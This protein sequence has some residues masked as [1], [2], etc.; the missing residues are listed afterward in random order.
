MAAAT[1]SPSLLL[2]PSCC[3]C[4]ESTL[5]LPCGSFLLGT[6]IQ[7]CLE[8]AVVAAVGKGALAWA[9]GSRS[10]K[11]TEMVRKRYLWLPAGPAF[12]RIQAAA[13]A[14]PPPSASCLGC[15]RCFSVLK[16]LM[17]GNFVRAIEDRQQLQPLLGVKGLP[18]GSAGDG[19]A[20]AATCPH[21]LHVCPQLILHR[22]VWW[23]VAW[24]WGRGGLEKDADSACSSSP[25]V[26]MWLT[27]SNNCLSL[28]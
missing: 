11:T 22:E 4:P 23:V 3:G 19:P 10:E 12:S 28:P 13:P 24:G 21:H 15:R 17:G 20:E 5:G 8:V 26:P 16:R 18:R 14:R 7:G 1:T 2:Q 25:K 27:S 6:G 9:L